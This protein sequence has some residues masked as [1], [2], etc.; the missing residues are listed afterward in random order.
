MKKKKDINLNVFSMIT[1]Y[2]ISKYD[3][4]ITNVNVNINVDVDAN[5][6]VE[7]MVRNVIQIKN[8][9]KNYFYVSAKIL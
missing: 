4:K 3:I 9:M 7:L 2:M 8:R 6:N 1:K 5:V